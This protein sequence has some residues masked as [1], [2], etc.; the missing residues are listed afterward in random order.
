LHLT[1]KRKVRND[2]KIFE[3][4]KCNICNYE[5]TNEFNFKIHYLNNHSSKEDKEDKED[6]K[7]NLKYYC[8]NCDF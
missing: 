4:L 2:K 1:G 6:R 7:N 3:P 8:D 5:S